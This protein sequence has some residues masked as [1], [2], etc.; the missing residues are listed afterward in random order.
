VT[1][2]T[3]SI[4]SLNP[5]SGV[6]GTSVTITGANFGAK[7]GDEHGEVQWHGGDADE[8]ERERALRFLFRAAQRPAMLW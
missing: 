8:L 6:V 2:P 4:T 3:P 5:T 1:V 7:P